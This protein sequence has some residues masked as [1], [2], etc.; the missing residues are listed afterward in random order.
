MPEITDNLDKLKV[1]TESL[2]QH[3]TTDATRRQQAV[4]MLLECVT[5]MV[6]VTDVN[7]IIKFA[8][9]SSYK[10]C[11]YTPDELVGQ[12]INLF[13]SDADVAIYKE[14]LRSINEKDEVLGCARNIVIKSKT[15]E[16][17]HA[18]LYLG[19]LKEDTSH[20]YIGVLHKGT[21]ETCHQTN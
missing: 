10:I 11:G 13:M 21:A 9:P 15:G 19:E 14:C 16:F 1:L 8:N 3:E 7:G 6:F 18:H 12:L 5:D 4:L 2:E 17:T 20:L